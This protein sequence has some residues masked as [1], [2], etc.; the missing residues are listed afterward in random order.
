MS[1]E[2]VDVVGARWFDERAQLAL[3]SE[4]DRYMLLHFGEEPGQDLAAGAISA[5]YTDETDPYADTVDAYLEAGDGEVGDLEIGL[6]EQD[7]G[8]GESG[9]FYDPSIEIDD[10]ER[11]VEVSTGVLLASLGDGDIA[12]SEDLLRDEELLQY[13]TDTA[14]EFVPPSQRRLDDEF[15]PLDD[16]SYERVE[17]EKSDEYAQLTATG[18]ESSSAQVQ[19][20][21]GA[22]GVAVEEVDT[23]RASFSDEEGGQ[24]AW[25]V[26]PETSELLYKEFLDRTG[27]ADRF[28]DGALDELTRVSPFSV[29]DELDADAELYAD[30][31]V[32]E[33]PE[34]DE[35]AMQVERFVVEAGDS[36][37]EAPGQL[38][39]HIVPATED[40]FH[41][42]NVQPQQGGQVQQD[43]PGLD[44]DRQDL[45]STG[46]GMFQ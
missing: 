4:D 9:Q 41:G 18:M 19:V 29:F 34:Q 39:Y 24:Y 44:A 21:D 25:E 14:W 7:F 28:Q 38:L 6:R 26:H 46:K 12:V 3:Q 36:V 17:S 27:Q 5:V 1:D 43:V 23:A 16:V 10:E 40:G 32:Q 2:Y 15:T 8:G 30:V 20:M 35:A 37:V 22:G 31:I 45:N 33:G 13:G 42:N 11:D